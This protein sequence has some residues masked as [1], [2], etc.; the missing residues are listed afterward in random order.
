[1]SR[2]TST[3]PL[4]KRLDSNTFYSPDGCH[5]WLGTTSSDGYGT[6]TV[7]KQTKSTH[8]ISYQVRKG[9][10]PDGMFVCHHCDNPICINPHHLFIGTHLDNMRDMVKKGRHKYGKNK[11]VF[12]RTRAR[13]R[14]KLSE[15]QV[16]EI[17]GFKGT[18]GRRK[19]SIKYNVSEGAIADILGNRNWKH[20]PR[21]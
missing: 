7:N 4:E 14:T 13:I 2:R 3:K 21:N 12:V 16:I 1:M 17:L 5:Y 18:L 10:I 15:A 20:I 8:R 9:P 6:I 11:K 19:L